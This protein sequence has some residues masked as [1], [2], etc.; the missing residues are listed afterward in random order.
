M[1]PLKI[2]QTANIVSFPH[3]NE[4]NSTKLYWYFGERQQNY[5]GILVKDNKI[6]IF[7]QNWHDFYGKNDIV[8]LYKIVAKIGKIS[9]EIIINFISV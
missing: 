1:S 8:F 3:K 2:V 9:L 7:W 6:D 5:I 4:Q